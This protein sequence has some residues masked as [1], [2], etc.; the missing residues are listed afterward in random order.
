M[1]KKKK[2]FKIIFT[3]GSLPL[4]V[5]IGLG[6]VKGVPAINEAKYKKLY[7]DT[8]EYYLR[9][10]WGKPVKLPIYNNTISVVFDNFSE[11]AKENAKHAISKLDDVL[12]TQNIVIYNNNEIKNDNY[13]GIHIAEDLGNKAGLICTNY[14][15]YTGEM[16]YPV[17]IEIAK[18]WVDRYNGEKKSEN[19]IFSSIIQ[20]EIGHALGLKDIKDSNL[21]K[22]SSMFWSIDGIASNYTEL[23]THNLRYIYD[24]DNDVYEVS[25]TTPNSMQLLSYHQQHK[26]EED[27]ILQM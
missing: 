8:F 15:Q 18:L 10:D 5:G 19:S 26:N 16:I 27:D 17:Q 4:G 14:N 3:I 12:K 6:I 1:K 24:R 23:D 22:K 7:G 25:V 21:Y 9:T 11:E 2:V 20:H 13:I